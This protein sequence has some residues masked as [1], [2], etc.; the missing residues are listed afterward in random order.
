MTDS[1]STSSPPME[2]GSLQQHQDGIAGCG[3]SEMQV[4]SAE[5]QDT[6]SP[7]LNELLSWGRVESK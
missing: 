4:R 7:A 5:G 3:A 2:N 1:H 6:C